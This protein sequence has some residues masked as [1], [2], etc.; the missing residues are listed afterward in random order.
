MEEKDIVVIVLCGLKARKEKTDTGILVVYFFFNY[1]WIFSLYNYKLIFS[2][3]S[4]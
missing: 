2:V 3:L 4:F 1:F